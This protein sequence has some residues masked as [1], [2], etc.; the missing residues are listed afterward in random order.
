[1]F[2]NLIIFIA[3]LQLSACS[4]F[5]PLPDR[6]GQQLVEGN[7]QN[8]EVLII[9]LPGIFSD[10]QDMMQRGVPDAIH[11]GWPEPDILM[12]DLTINFYRKGLATKRLHDEIVVPARQQGYSEVWLSGGSM[13]GM[14]TLMYEWQHPGEMDG[15][16]LISPYMG[17]GDVTD[18][19]REAGGLKFWDS[20]ERLRVMQSDNY[21]RLIWQMAQD[22]IGDQAKLERVW[23][24]CGDEDRLYP[25]VQMLGAILPEDRYFPGSGGH[26][27]DYWIPNIE[28]IFHAVAESRR[29]RFSELN[30]LIPQPAR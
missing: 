18:A 8:R 5:G 25:D 11:R 15:L 22:W 19:I 28:K 21:D 26:S 23:L 10:S 1:M 27:W 20:G 16:V 12:A 6:M 24:M 3:T 9:L 7:Q 4:I 29:T 17:S 30:G 14:G 2:R 13:G